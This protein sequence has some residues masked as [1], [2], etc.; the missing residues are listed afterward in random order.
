MSMDVAL[1]E[2]MAWGWAG[3]LAAAV[4]AAAFLWA[5]AWCW[6]W[7]AG[8]TTRGTAARMESDARALAHYRG[9]RLIALALLFGL[10]MAFG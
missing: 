6:D 4:L 3:K 1:R 8:W 2:A 5:V 9:Q 10:V 7:R